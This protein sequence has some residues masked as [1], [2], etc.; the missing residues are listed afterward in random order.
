MRDRSSA[1]QVLAAQSLALAEAGMEDARLKLQQDLFFPPPTSDEQPRFH[2]VEEFSEPVASGASGLA[3]SFEVT[4][5]V[6]WAQPPQ[7]IVK[8]ISVGVVGPRDRPLSVRR[9]SAEYDLA[10]QDRSDASRPNPTCG[11]Y[12]HW[13][14]EG[15]P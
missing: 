8:V 9:V 10:L 6:T 12:L 11:R 1:R 15:G 5:D 14:D 13:L 2:Y 7:Q 4:V 3:G